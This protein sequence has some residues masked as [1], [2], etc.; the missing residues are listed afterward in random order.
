MIFS[1]PDVIEF[2]KKY[3][4]V[5]VTIADLVAYRKNHEKMIHR[6]AEA[7]LPSK[8][9]KF[10]IIAYENDLD[11]LCH[12]AIVKGDIAPDLKNVS[13]GKIVINGVSYEIHAGYRPRNP[14]GSIHHTEFEVK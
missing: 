9:G 3:D 8:Y 1:E 11:D 4:L 13:D 2:A 12:V 14:N 6:V 5:F 10:R 7:D